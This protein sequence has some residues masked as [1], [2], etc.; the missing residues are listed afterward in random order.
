MNLLL[1]NDIIMEAN[2]MAAEIPWSNY[3]VHN[4]FTAYSADGAREII[5]NNTI[6][7]LLC[8]I[9]MPG[10]NGLSLIQWINSNH[11]D[12][13]C[14]LLTCHADFSYAREGI[15]LGCEDYLLLP[16]TYEQIGNSVNKVTER[17]LVRQQ[18]VRLQNYGKNWLH[19]QSAQLQITDT[20]SLKPTD[21]MDNCIQYILDHIN[22]EELSVT[23]VA[24][25]VY[26]NPVYL[27]RVFKKEKGMNISQWITKERMELA[28]SLL[29]TTNLTAT[30]V[31]FR[32]GF[33]NYP[34]FSTLF[35]SYFGLSPSQF[36]KAQEKA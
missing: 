19:S 12:I 11:Y 8:D 18:D 22:D 20:A 2:T 17:R 25:N 26:L 6:D 23:K 35:K 3:G 21:L 33:R 10:E 14:I 24:A 4:V 30:E 27:N 28:V 32:V 15:S 1:V 36:V 31:A 7:I 16:T 34:Y 5:L 29:N 9:E 13:S